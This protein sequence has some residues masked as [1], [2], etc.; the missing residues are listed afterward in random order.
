MKPRTRFVLSLGISAIVGLTH[1]GATAA[2]LAYDGF[3]ISMPANG[4]SGTGFG[5]PWVNLGPVFEVGDPSLCYPGLQTTGFSLTQGT[6]NA[7]SI[8]RALPAATGAPGT[9]L[10]VSFLLEPQGASAGFTF[11]GLLL[12]GTAGVAFVG[13][14]GA[15]ATG[16]YVLETFGGFGQLASTVPAEIGTAALMVV[17]IQFNAGGDLITLFAN[18]VPGAGEPGIG[19]TKADLQLGPLQS[20]DFV[21]LGMPFAFDELRLGTTYGDVVP[22]DSKA[23]KCK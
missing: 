2:L 1:A 9:T 6:V 22:A 18:P 11:S 10:Y 16:H 23:R 8:G 21:S 13:K 15:G 19:L 20:F 5:G 12:R 3:R 14:P 17:K 7:T 4:L